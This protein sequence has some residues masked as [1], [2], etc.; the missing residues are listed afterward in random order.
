MTGRKGFKIAALVLVGAGASW[1]LFGFNRTQLPDGTIT[2]YRFFGRVT[3]IDSTWTGNDGKTRRQRLVFTWSKPFRNRH[4]VTGCDA[5]F[6]E[7]WNDL[8]G[9]GL[10]DTW[11]YRVGPDA[12]GTCQVEYRVDTK[13]SGRPDWVF[14]L[15]YGEYKKA[16]AMMI[17]RRGF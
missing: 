10:W 9:D 15:P 16:N 1:W 8:N 13:N 12:T 2:A 14:R 3:R 5:I 11:I 4:W 7:S 17:A 6:P